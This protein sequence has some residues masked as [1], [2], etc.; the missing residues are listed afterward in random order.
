MDVPTK[1]CKTCD[2]W[3]PP[4]THHCRVC[5]NCVETQDH[6]CVWLNNCVGRRNYRFFFTFIT[7]GTLLGLFL[8][9]SSIGHIIAWP[10]A[11]DVSPDGVEPSFTDSISHNRVPFAMFIYGILASLYPLALVGYH[12]FLMCRGET[13]REYMQSHKFAR[14]DRHRP[15]SQ[16]SVWRNLVA[17]LIRPRPPT[18]L[19]FKEG[20]EQGDQRFGNEKRGF[21]SRRGPLNGVEMTRVGMK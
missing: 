14:G 1:F 20:L 9:G 17:V 21:W 7:S 2:I 5:D 6:H 12:L 8:A 10:G 19:R 15:Y 13:T 11:Q 4:R 16:V 3:R 18:Y